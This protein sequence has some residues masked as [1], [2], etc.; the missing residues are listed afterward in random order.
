MTFAILTRSCALRGVTA[1]VKGARRLTMP[2]TT[3]VTTSTTKPAA[4]PMMPRRFM[5]GGG[6]HQ[7]VSRSMEAELFGGHPKEEGWEKT[8]YI[9]YAASFVLISFALGFAPDTSIKTWAQSEARA[10]LVLQAEGKLDQPVFGVH[11]DTPENKFDFESVN[12]DNPFNE[13]DDDEEEE[14]EDEEDEEEDDEE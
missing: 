1:S 3:A 9:T 6:G 13:E 11:Y 14:E 12:P 2:G 4:A 5:G 7:P 8:V 10:R